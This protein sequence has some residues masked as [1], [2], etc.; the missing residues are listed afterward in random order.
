M[1]DSTVVFESDPSILEEVSTPLWFERM[2]GGRI[3]GQTSRPAG[4]GWNV[5]SVGGAGSG[6]GWH[7]HG[8]SWLGAVHGRKRWFVCPPGGLSAAEIGS[9]LLSSFGW[10]GR[11]YAAVAAGEGV[12][13]YE[14]EQV[15]GELMYLP[16]GWIHA[17]LAV[18][19]EISIGFGGQRS[20]A[21]ADGD[22]DRWWEPVSAAAHRGDREAATAVGQRLLSD[23]SK[24][25]ALV[26]LRRAAARQGAEGYAVKERLATLPLLEPTE[27]VRACSLLSALCSLLSA[28]LLSPPVL[29]SCLLLTVR[30]ALSYLPNLPRVCL[31]RSHRPW[32]HAAKYAAKEPLLTACFVLRAR[33]HAGGRSGRLPGGCP[34]RAHQRLQCRPG[35][36]AWAPP[37][38]PG[39]GV[40][41]GRTS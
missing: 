31:V 3:A 36:N 12:P 14:A 41:A 18:G 15:A 19:E 5:L 11:H 24:A 8:E 27:V 23:G 21:A 2:A 4:G 13:C 22:D 17:T 1:F 34:R 6:V 33:A 10:V 7:A 38:V 29:F 26:W 9:P 35:R 39:R 25:E 28:L 40:A 30:S 32:L 37:Y 16:P 20:Y